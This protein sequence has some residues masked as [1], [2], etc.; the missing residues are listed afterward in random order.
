MKIIAG[1]CFKASTGAAA[2]NHEAVVILWWLIL[3]PQ[4][5]G[6]HYPLIELLAAAAVVFAQQV[7]KF[8]IASHPD[9]FVIQ[10]DRRYKER[11]SHLAQDLSHTD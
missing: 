2:E 10:P 7:L 9:H 4:A 5:V 3:A 11:S 8:F 1:S 6:G